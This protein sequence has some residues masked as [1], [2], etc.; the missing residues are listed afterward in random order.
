MTMLSLR[1]AALGRRG[2]PNTDL[3]IASPGKKRRVHTDIDVTASR[4]CETVKQSHNIIV[5][6]RVVAQRFFMQIL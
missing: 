6:S 2:S 4:R 1:A 3:E 5:S